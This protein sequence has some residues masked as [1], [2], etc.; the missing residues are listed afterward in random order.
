MMLA[1]GLV[2][3]AEQVRARAV[4]LLASGLAA[5]PAAALNLA[6]PAVGNQ[7]ISIDM[8]GTSFEVCAIRD[9]EVPTTTESWVGNTASRSRWSTLA[10]SARVVAASPRST[11]LG[12]R[13][14]PESAGADPGP[15]CYGKGNTEPTVTDANVVLGYVPADYF[16]GGDIPLDAAKAHEAVG[17]LAERLGMT[18]EGAAAAIIDTVNAQMADLIGG[19]VH[20]PR[21]GRPRLLARR[22]RRGGSGACGVPGRSPR[23]PEGRR[24]V[25]RGALQRVRDA[26]D[27]SRT[28][29]RALARRPRRGRRPE[30]DWPPIRGDGEDGGGRGVRVARARTRRPHVRAHCRDALRRPVSRGRDR[31]P[32]GSRRGGDD[33]GRRGGAA[34]PTRRSFLVRDA[35]GAGA[36]PDL[37]GRRDRG[38]ARSSW[39]PAVASGS[40][41]SAAIRRTRECWW[42]G[43]L[44][45]TPAYDGIPPRPG[46]VLFGP[47]VIE[48]RST[49]IVVPGGFR[50]S[51][52]ERRN[53]VLERA[54]DGGARDR[55][56]TATGAEA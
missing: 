44:V 22:R 2:Q 28:R 11:A 31:V 39:R 47:A 54:A 48:E 6:A 25:C 51:V 14:G 23:H 24:P 56:L 42:A 34:R 30:G 19:G 37:P 46:H 50:C 53:Y 43:E 29:L 41:A 10:A 35:V 7:L 8:G 45:E 21:A 38:G 12:L 55:V 15:A 40:D 17:R 32:R 27:G 13:V 18:V 16:L 3:T 1:N 36:V 9:G 20:P 33:R 5:A 4:Y 52:D 49:T 26:D